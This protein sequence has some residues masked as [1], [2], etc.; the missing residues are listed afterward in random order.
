MNG[1]FW[2]APRFASIWGL[3]PSYPT[4]CGTSRMGTGAGTHG[5]DSSYPQ[6]LNIFRHPDWAT[7]AVKPDWKP[8]DINWSTLI[9][10]GYDPARDWAE[11]ELGRIV[12]D[13]HLDY[14]K[15]D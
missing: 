10:L 8:E 12:S 15:H 7:E 1:T 14:L 6:A 4:P 2:A 5:G 3:K 13:N 9:D 11:Q